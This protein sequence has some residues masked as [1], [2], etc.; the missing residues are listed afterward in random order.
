[1]LFNIIKTA[2]SSIAEDSPS[3]TTNLVIKLYKPEIFHFLAQDNGLSKIDILAS[4]IKSLPEETMFNAVSS[5]LEIQ[6]GN[7]QKIEDS[8]LLNIESI[9]IFSV[10]SMDFSETTASNNLVKLLKKI[11][12][13][14]IFLLQKNSLEFCISECKSIDFYFEYT[15]VD[16]IIFTKKETTENNTRKN[17]K[18]NTFENDKINKE[19]DT[20]TAILDWLFPVLSPPISLDGAD[21]YRPIRKYQKDGINFLMHQKTVLL[22]DEMGTGKTVQAV[23]AARIL[24]STKKID[25]PVLVVCPVSLIGSSSMSERLG[26]PEG[27]EGHF[28]FW[29][30]DLTTIIIRGQKNLRHD[31]WQSHFH[32]Y[33]TTYDTLRSDILPNDSE[34]A[35]ESLLDKF[36]CIILDEAQSIKNRSPRRSKAVKRLKSEYR[37][38]LSGTPIENK[39]DDII[40]IFEFIEPSILKGLH[41]IACPAILAQSIKPYLIRRLTKDVLPDLPEKQEEDIWV[42]LDT[43]QRKEYDILH[44]EKTKEIGESKNKNLDKGRIQ[45]TVFNLQQICNFASD[46][47][48]SPKSHV[49]LEILTECQ[50]SHKKTIVFSRFISEQ[51][52]INKIYN[53]LTL[54]GIKTVTLLGSDGSRKR[55]N[56]ISEF[57]SNPDI[58]AILI[59]I[60][61]GAFG[62]N[63]PEADYVIHFDP[64]WNPAIRAQATDR[65]YRFGREKH[66]TLTIYNLW[67]RDTIEER[68][69]YKLNEKLKISKDILDTLVEKINPKDIEQKITIEDWYE[70]LEMKKKL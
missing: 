6:A 32:V 26:K 28:Y 47:N 50:E 53:F 19:E 23:L 59:S 40:S 15:S 24:I 51:Y 38:A 46:R 39:L 66:R 61:A 4:K 67:T 34:D 54:H 13:D 45:H 49:L 20:K 29:A 10:L 52:G 3:I 27:W 21:L 43:H 60:R 35:I 11:K 2:Y 56:S 69:Q 25:K 16:G 42:E 68:I 31:L 65:A 64:D 9:K 48:S 63:L 22:A 1:M 30:P 58:T 70:I 44:N 7:I 37:W 18:K 33:L 55:E 14:D 62:L 17:E 8:N 12:S 5:G 57:K 36:G 41:H